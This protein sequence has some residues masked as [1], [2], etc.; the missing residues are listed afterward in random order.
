MVTAAEELY[1]HSKY[2]ASG[3]VQIDQSSMQSITDFLHWTA[4]D[5]VVKV[6]SVSMKENQNSVHLEIVFMNKVVWICLRAH[7]V[8]SYKFNS[9]GT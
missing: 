2:L 3:S 6:I 8:G 1:E 7:C 9:H 4:E 5:S